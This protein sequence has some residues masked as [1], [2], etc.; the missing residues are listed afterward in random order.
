MCR[1]LRCIRLGEPSRLVLQLFDAD[2]A[3]CVQEQEGA[4]MPDDQD[5]Q[6]GHDGYM[7]LAPLS[8]MAMLAPLPFAQISDKWDEPEGSRV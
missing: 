2:S 8:D 7:P 4:P 5:G 3:A 6:E 1:G